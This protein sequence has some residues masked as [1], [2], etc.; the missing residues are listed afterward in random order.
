[1]ASEMTTAE[2]VEYMRNESESVASIAVMILEFGATPEQHA[3][4]TDRVQR[5]R[6]IADRL[7]Q[8]AAATARAEKAE[9]ERDALRN[10]AEKYRAWITANTKQ[11][12]ELRR[13]LNS[14]LND[15][16]RKEAGL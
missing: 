9:A 6:A 14:D 2:M 8:L 13:V 12:S 10:D 15:A 7:E 1:M 5:Y 3:N 16:A 11:R 4:A